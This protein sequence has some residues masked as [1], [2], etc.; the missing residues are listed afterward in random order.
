MAHSVTDLYGVTPDV[1][2]KLSG[3]GFSTSDEL[4]DAVAHPANRKALAAQLGMDE[5]ALLEL[6]N[7]ADLARIKGIGKEYSDLLEFAGVDTVA[8]LAT[9][10]PANLYAKLQEV[11]SQFTFIHLPSPEEVES[12]V[13]QAKGLDRKLYY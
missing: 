4:L 13:H 6:G 7:R 11:A 2:D 5:R 10:S 3:A 1:A 9:R 8:E 12:W